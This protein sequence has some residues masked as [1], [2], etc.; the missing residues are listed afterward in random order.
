MSRRIT[1][2]HLEQYLLGE[3]PEWVAEAI[4]SDPG[5]RRRLKAL[6]KDTVAFH[7]SYPTD[8]M[9]SSIMERARRE[10]EAARE[11]GG[12]TDRLLDFP[13][14]RVGAF[15]RR[16]APPPVLA[17]GA[18]AALALVILIPTLQNSAPGIVS[19]TG[20][21][22]YVRL[23]GFEP[24]LSVYRREPGGEVVK[25]ASGERVEA[26]DSLQLAYN[27]AGAA[28]GMI[29]SVDGRGTVT[30]HF[31]ST[32][33]EAENLTSPGEIPLSYSYVLDD[34]PLF[35]RFFFVAAT[36]RLDVPAIITATEELLDR[37]DPGLLD[38]PGIAEVVA[39]ETGLEAEEFGV[40]SVTVRKQ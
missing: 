11:E 32:P 25:L 31:P 40:E 34:A 6:E 30:L 24:S 19:P 10:Q 13:G 21:D 14:Q 33:S 2:F 1:D 4:S 3:A 5:A 28:Y 17:F 23:K 7:N 26:G 8:E 39:A 37:T 22:E 35:E 16:L 18:L 29:L 15:L 36:E 38:A 27:S 9:V 20:Q 12:T